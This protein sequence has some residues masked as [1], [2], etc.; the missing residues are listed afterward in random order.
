MQIIEA[1]TYI[2]YAWDENR[3]EKYVYIC[4]PVTLITIKYKETQK[5][6]FIFWN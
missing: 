5:S 1:Q 4:V 3:D 2:R 6:E